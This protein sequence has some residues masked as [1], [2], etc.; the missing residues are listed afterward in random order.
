MTLRFRV[1]GFPVQI[2]PLFLLTALAT[3]ATGYRG[4][5]LMLV[6]S[7]VVFV[8]VLI[9]ELGHALAYRRFGG[10]A[11]I[12]LHGLGGTTTGEGAEQLTHRQ[13]LW[14][15]LAGPA[16]GFLLGGLVLALQS[17]TPVGQA[18]GLVAFAVGALL[19]VNFGWG[20]INLLPM[21]PLDGG[22]ALA[23]VIRERGGPRYEWLIPLI[24]VVT[25]VCC[26]ALA[27]AWKQLWLG[28]LALILGVMNLPRLL[29]ARVS[30]RYILQ[31]RAASTRRRPASEEG[32]AALRGVDQLLSELR[33]PSRSPPPVGRS[34]PPVRRAPPP[35]RV[36][37]PALPELPHD[38][39]FVG[40]LLL[41]SGLA[42]LAIRPLQAAFAEQPTA[43]TGHSLAA[44]LLAARRHAELTRL[45]TGPSARHLGA[46]TLAL[47]ASRAEAAAQPELAA[48]A[49][50]LH[51]DHTRLA[52]LSA[53]RAHDSEK[54][55]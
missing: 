29:E 27:I 15:S 52:P 37:E 39:R 17:L 42:E 16:A 53:P 44:A 41:D 45:L 9:H 23:A 19:W 31:L 38:P 21:V 14:V 32:D 51:Q 30:R 8:S 5:G 43:Q 10:A 33:R 18:G 7:C 46:E 1:A 35:P 3:G 13:S 34:A 55:D 50:A 24:S 40:E 22:H 4:V 49:R 54:P 28:M 12:Q 48:R 47:I 25:A 2:H 11:S 26:I 36:P 6:W 20:L